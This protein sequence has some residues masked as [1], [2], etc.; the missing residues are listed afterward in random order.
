MTAATSEAKHTQALLTAG[1]QQVN[2]SF[3]QHL[4]SSVWQAE[5]ASNAFVTWKHVRITKVS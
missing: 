1:G 2:T 3:R 4:V 5:G